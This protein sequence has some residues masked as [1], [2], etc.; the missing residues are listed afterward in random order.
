MVR[1]EV[2]IRPFVRFVDFS[3]QIPPVRN[4]HVDPEPRKF[5]NETK[6]GRMRIFIRFDETR[7]LSNL[8]HAIEER[9]KA[10]SL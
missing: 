5:R 10:M 8:R 1:H 4:V 7:G 3:F 2:T 9:T 6:C